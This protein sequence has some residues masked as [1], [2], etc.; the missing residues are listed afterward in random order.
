[1]LKNPYYLR[2]STKQHI[3]LY[4]DVVLTKRQRERQERASDSF[5]HAKPV[6]VLEIAKRSF[7]AQF[8][9]AIR[10]SL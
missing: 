8:P 6:P 2:E 9:G 10:I 4:A 7:A 1:M 3:I 5:A